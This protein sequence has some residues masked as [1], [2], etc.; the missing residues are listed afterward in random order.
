MPTTQTVAPTQETGCVA[1]CANNTHPQAP[2][3][4]L[5]TNANRDT[6]RRCP[7]HT[8]RPASASQAVR[9]TNGPTALDHAHGARSHGARS[10]QGPRY[11]PADFIRAG[12]T[13]TRPFTPKSSPP[14]QREK[15]QVRGVL[16]FAN[17]C[18]RGLGTIF[19]QGVCAVTSVARGGMRGRKTGGAWFH[20]GTPR[21]TPKRGLS[22]KSRH[23][24]RAV[25]AVEEVQ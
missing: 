6:T 16:T 7:S 3:P 10:S 12:G 18:E 19:T 17:V 1:L 9:H 15:L 21:G 5:A 8:N 24:P 4:Q 11:P 2:T 14:P 23:L 13:S 22:V 20:A 25:R